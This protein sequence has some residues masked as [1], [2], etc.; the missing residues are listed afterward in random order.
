MSSGVEFST[1]GV[2][3]ELNENVDLGV[4]NIFKLEMLSLHK[5]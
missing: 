4:F 5:T 2:M 1:W 3:L